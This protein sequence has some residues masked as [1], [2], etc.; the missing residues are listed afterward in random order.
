MTC[1]AHLTVTIKTTVYEMRCDEPA[2]H[3]GSEHRSPQGSTWTARVPKGWRER[4]R[5][6][7]AEKVREA[8]VPYPDPD[9]EDSRWARAFN[10]GRESV[11]DACHQLRQ[12]P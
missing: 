7:L 4:L 2:G 6:K 3:E 8:P 5:A 10:S 1:D 9:G 11:L 12:M